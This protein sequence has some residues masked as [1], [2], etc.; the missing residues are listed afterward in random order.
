MAGEAERLRGCEGCSGQPAGGSGIQPHPGAALNLGADFSRL[1]PILHNNI[2][3]KYQRLNVCFIH[4]DL[5]C[6][7][8]IAHLA[9][10]LAASSL[11]M[12]WLIRGI[13]GDRSTEKDDYSNRDDVKPLPIMIVT[14]KHVSTQSFYPRTEQL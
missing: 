9:D 14:N 12:D 10:N 2:L 8:V 1:Q 3:T 13:L 11:N 6:W 7:H 5:I 4:E